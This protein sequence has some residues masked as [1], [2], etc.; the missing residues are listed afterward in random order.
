MAAELSLDGQTFIQQST[1]QL[2]HYHR[3]GMFLIQSRGV[4]DGG[5]PLTKR[6]A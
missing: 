4:V 2:C 3:V 5:D 1:E 6:Q